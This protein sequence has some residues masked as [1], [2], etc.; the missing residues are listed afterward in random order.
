VWISIHRWTDAT[1]STLL[2]DHLKHV[3]RQLVGELKDVDAARRSTDKKI[4]AAAERKYA[5]ASRLRD[6]LDD[7]IA[8]VTQCAERG[9]PSADARASRARWTRSSPWTWTTAS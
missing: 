7:F 9:A 8:A 5:S 1:L 3:E 6:E 4:V 2:V